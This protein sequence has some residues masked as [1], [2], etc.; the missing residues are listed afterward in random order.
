MGS[1]LRSDQYK[2]LR[3]LWNQRDLGAFFVLAETWKVPSVLLWVVAKNVDPDRQRRYLPPLDPMELTTFE[4][5][6]LAYHIWEIYPMLSS[7]IEG[8]ARQV[9]SYWDESTSMWGSKPKFSP[10]NRV[11]LFSVAMDF[12]CKPGLWSKMRDYLSE[13]RFLVSDVEGWHPMMRVPHLG[14]HVVEAILFRIAY[15]ARY[16][17][18]DPTWAEQIEEIAGIV[19]AQFLY[20]DLSK[21]QRRIQ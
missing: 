1:A 19:Y 7:E 9:I 4:V 11:L 14:R 3:D 18:P 12:A 17:D 16:V 2:K 8:A 21:Y 15:L 6:H 10:I 5:G 20:E 13:I